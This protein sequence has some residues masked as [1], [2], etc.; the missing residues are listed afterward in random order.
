MKKII[1]TFLTLLICF[2]PA[3]IIADTVIF[4][5][6]TDKLI[7]SRNGSGSGT[8]PIAGI[9]GIVYSTAGVAS[10]VTGTAT[11]CVLVNGTS[12]SC[13][14]GSGVTVIE[15]YNVVGTTA[16]HDGNFL[17]EQ[18]GNNSPSGTNT[19]S[20]TNNFGGTT[21]FTGG[22]V[23]FTGATVT[24]LSTGSSGNAKL[25]SVNSQSADTLDGTDK[26]IGGASVSIAAGT[27]GAGNC[28]MGEF[29]FVNTGASTKTF[30]MHLGAFSVSPSTTAASTNMVYNARICYDPSSTTS[31]QGYTW[32]LI[33][34]TPA[35][36]TASQPNTGTTADSSAN[37]LT[38]KFTSNGTGPDTTQLRSAV[39]TVVR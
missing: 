2:V 35:S 28:I 3:L 8:N 15:G 4:D 11:D 39:F 31:V 34:S 16:T 6:M 7:I 38:L 32:G 21:D 22:T 27:I 14:S 17:F 26:T 25:L 30:K 19:W 1:C 9:T 24:G 20:G 5:P 13:G 33:G 23:D 36:F 10:G 12:G 29:A 18:A 37:A